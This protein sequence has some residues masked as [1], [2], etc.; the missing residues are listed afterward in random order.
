[1]RRFPNGKL[2]QSA[3]FLDRAPRWLILSAMLRRLG[4]CRS[5]PLRRGRWLVVED[6]L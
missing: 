2:G 3:V 1:M 5:D 6:P 4:P